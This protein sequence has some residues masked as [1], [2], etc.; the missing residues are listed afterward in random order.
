MP[1]NLFLEDDCLEGST[2]F[3]DEEV[4]L[5]LAED[6]STAHSSDFAT[7]TSTGRPR[8][9]EDEG[10]ELEWD[11]PPRDKKGLV[12]SQQPRKKRLPTKASEAIVPR[13]KKARKSKT[14]Q[15]WQPCKFLRPHLRSPSSSLSEL[16]KLAQPMIPVLYGPQ[17][18][19]RI[20]GI[21]LSLFGGSGHVCEAWSE[22]AREA[23]CKT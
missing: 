10:I 18:S 23:F 21:F 11:F 15:G 6:S 19:E 16:C 17:Q 22:A 8:D 12:P 9:S 4:G 14:P 1:L 13:L 7:G 5:E 2:S 20:P 3:F